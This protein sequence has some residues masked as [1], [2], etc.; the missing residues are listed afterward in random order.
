MTEQ[1]QKSPL[2]ELRFEGKA[3]QDGRILLDD[4]LLFVDNLHSAI[5][6]VIEVLERGISGLPGR[7]PKTR[8][9]LAALEIVALKRGSFEMALDLRRDEGELL[10]GFDL[11][12]KA[13]EKLMLGLEVMENEAPLPE[14]F[15]EGVL[16]SLRDAGRVIDHG[17]EIVH[18]TSTSEIGTR[19]VKFVQST[20]DQIVTRIRR[21][22]HAWTEAEGRLLMA[23]FK[24]DSLRCRLH[25]STG[26]AIPCSFNED[27]TERVMSYLRRFVQ[28]RGDATYDPATNVI[29]SLVIRDIEPIERLSEIGV[30]FMPPS[31]FWETKS[32]DELAMEQGVYPVEDWDRLSGQWPE[33]ADFDSFLEAI[34]SLREN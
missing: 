33:G 13:I 12:Q 23:D 8:Q 24:E 19:R 22:Q 15:D 16:M 2:L 14:G 31:A 3:V 18:L 10:P 32:L 4:L 9:I 1:S 34:R 11:G 7:P 28:V 30:S 5:S 29:R 21:L 25:P 26:S 20:R 17:V 6:R 27:M